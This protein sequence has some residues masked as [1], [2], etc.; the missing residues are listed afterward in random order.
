[1]KYILSSGVIAPEWGTVINEYFKDV[2]GR[3]TIA[4]VPYAKDTESWDFYF[5]Y[6]SQLEWWKRFVEFYTAKPIVGADVINTKSEIF[7]ADIAVFSGGT[8][9]NLL[10]SI[11]MDRLRAAARG[12]KIFIG[13]S[14]GA[15]FL[16]QYCYGLDAKKI[17]FCNGPVPIRTIVHF[18][19]DYGG[20]TQEIW[21][22]IVNEM[23]SIKVDGEVPM[24]ALQ[25]NEYMVLDYE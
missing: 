18:K 24:V 3:L 23:A 10:E 20:R 12:K 5:N 2:K 15:N 16:S 7:T 14:A 6:Y 1:M 17:L 22:Q 4:Y 25:D 19:S 13:L 11:R 9:V 21:T 8:T